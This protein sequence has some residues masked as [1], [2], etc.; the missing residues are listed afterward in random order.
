MIKNIFCKVNYNRSDRE[1][2]KGEKYI[3]DFNAHYDDFSN[4]PEFDTTVFVYTNYEKQIGLYFTLNKEGEK[5]YNTFSYLWNNFETESQ[6]R[7]RKLNEIQKY[8][9]TMQKRKN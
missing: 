4:N 8:S 3:V 9:Y 6:H 2:I 1:F 5:N 7:K